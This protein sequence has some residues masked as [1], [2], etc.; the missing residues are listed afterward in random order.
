MKAEPLFDP[1]GYG[2]AS[3][4]SW[5][6]KA[7]AENPHVPGTVI[8]F[9]DAAPHGSKRVHHV[10]R[11]RNFPAREAARIMINTG[12]AHPPRAASK[13]QNAP[14]QQ[15]NY[16]PFHLFGEQCRPSLE[17]KTNDFRIEKPG[18]NVAGRGSMRLHP[19]QDAAVVYLQPRAKI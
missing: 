15:K 7:I 13:E 10:S 14:R 18:A 5:H 1:A 11:D 12:D 3:V 16:Q 6:A 8:H 17:L 4:V 2:N 19:T 9:E